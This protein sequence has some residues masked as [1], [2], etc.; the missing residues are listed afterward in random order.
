MYVSKGLIFH[1]YES[2][3]D[4]VH[5]KWGFRLHE[6]EEKHDATARKFA[7]AALALAEK[8]NVHANIYATK[9]KNLVG[10]TIYWVHFR[11]T[12]RSWE[13]VYRALG[14]Y[15]GKAGVMKPETITK[16]LAAVGA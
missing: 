15:G 8:E 10:E 11:G 14:G 5:H 3:T 12:R 2:A 9:E 4:T 13:R 1:A 16:A 7:G 6:L